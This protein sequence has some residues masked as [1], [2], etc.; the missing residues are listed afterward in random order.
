MVNRQAP[1][2]V[3][4]AVMNSLKG[5]VTPRVGLEYIA[6]GRAREINALLH[7][8]DIIKDG[9]AAFR[10]IVGRYGSGKSFLLQTMRNYALDRG[11]AAADADL[12]PERRLA[13]GGRQGL[14]TYRE[15]IR[16]I[17]VKTRPDGG[18]LQLILERWISSIQSDVVVETG[19]SSDAPSFNEAVYK[20]VHQVAQDMESMVNGFDFANAVMV[21]YRAYITG[22]DELRSNIL[23]WFRGEY[24]TKTEAKRDFGINL[25]INDNNWYDFIKLLSGFLVK[26]GYNGLLVLIDELVNLF[27]VPN[28]I[29]RQINYEMILMMYN[30][31]LQGKAQYLGF[32][33]CATPQCL[34]DQ[35]KGI[36]SYDAL[37][38]RLTEG[39][40]ATENS[41]D[42]L[43]PIIRLEPLTHEEMYVLLEN[44][45]RIHA[46]L[47]NYE[48]SVSHENLIYFLQVEYER[49]GADTHITPREII[50][51]FIEL[52]NIIYQNPEKSIA[53]ILGGARFIITNEYDPTDKFADF[54]V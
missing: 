3:A 12:S 36:F 35:H 1:R 7:D 40:F 39:R 37:R 48:V 8:I 45:A 38:S 16:N 50:R 4:S 11:F 13:G 43:A 28:A 24:A 23:R 42:L 29:T 51:D 10:F 2:R 26:A 14:A 47:Y 34:E 32:F 19:L 6:V 52:I 31:M 41:K 18:A 33:M 54:E 27:R 53:E 30:D 49:I 15:L 17:S 21:Y 44:L 25:I 20:R 5:G 46:D 9:G 22:D